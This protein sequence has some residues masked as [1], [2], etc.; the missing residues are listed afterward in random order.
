MQWN[1]YKLNKNEKAY[2]FLVILSHGS[3]FTVAVAEC[4][5]STVLPLISACILTL[6]PKAG[7]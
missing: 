2:F 6:T 5:A 1:Q 4:D 7:E 3:K